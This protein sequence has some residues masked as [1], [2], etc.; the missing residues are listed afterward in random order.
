MKTNRAVII[1]FRLMQ[2]VYSPLLK[3]YKEMKKNECD[4]Y[5]GLFYIFLNDG[6]N[7]CLNKDITYFSTY[8]KTI[9][10]NNVCKDIVKIY[11]K[12]KKDFSDTYFNAL[13]RL[14]ECVKRDCEKL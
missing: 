2:S 4:Y 14:L 1:G 10:I 5:I 12:Y 3:F 6:L 13:N 8:N 7:A 11:D 9:T